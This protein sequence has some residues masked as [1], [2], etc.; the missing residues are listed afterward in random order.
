VVA[1]PLIVIEHLEEL[2][3]K[4][5][6]IEYI[7]ARRI[8]GSQLV[9]TNAGKCCS[10]LSRIARCYPQSIT[11]LQGEL[12]SSPENVIVLDP[13]AEKVLTSEEAAKAE[14][15]VVGGILGDH[16]PR[17][18]T[19][20]LLTSRFK[21]AKPRNIGPHQF[22]ID[23]AVYVAF[24]IAMGA[25]LNDIRVALNP[26]IEVDLGEYGTVTVEL[27]Y[28]YPIVNG[29]PL[30]AEELLQHISSGVGF[31]ELRAQHGSIKSCF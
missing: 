16:P 15:I 12:Y 5:V 18:R 23:G 8:V 28:A 26:S 3:S 30:I 13:A 17:G 11:E 20:K 24:Q 19:R 22:S 27:P 29:K 7:N 9:I 6:V 31:E 14:A 4:W 10:E 2:L 21:G 25:S 1:R